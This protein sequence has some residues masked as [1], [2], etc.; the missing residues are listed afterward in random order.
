MSV[1][2]DYSFHH[3]R[4]IEA[5]ELPEG[6]FHIIPSRVSSSP[7]DSGVIDRIKDDWSRALG[8]ESTVPILD[9]KTLSSFLHVYPECA[10][11]E[12]G[13]LFEFATIAALWNSKHTSRG[14]HQKIVHLAH[15]ILTRSYGGTPSGIGNGSGYEINDLYYDALTGILSQRGRLEHE[16]RDFLKELSAMLETPMKPSLDRMSFDAYKEQRSQNSAGKFASLVIPI[17]HRLH[18]SE[19]EQASVAS[20][21]KLGSLI[22]GLASDY[23]S[24]HV[25]FDKH[26]TSD[27]L[28]VISN[29]MA[30]LM[31]NYGYTEE[32]AS[33]ILKS[34]ILFLERQFLIDYDDWKASPG[35]KATDLRAYMALWVTSVGGACY[36]QAISPRYHGLKLKTTAEDRAQLTGRN[37]IHYKLHG[38][39]PPASSQKSSDTP[40]KNVTILLA[41]DQRDILA[42]FKKAPAEQLCMAPYEYTR[43]TPGKKMMSKF[44]ECLRTW[45]E[46]PDTSATIIEHVTD[47]IFQSTLMIDDIED[48]SMLRRGKPAAHLV[49]GKSQTINSATYLYA[50][51]SRDL[52]QLQQDACKTA[53]LDELETLALGQALD[54]HWKFQKKCPTTSHY[55][56]MV[57]NKTGGLFRMALR[58]MEIE[59]KTEPCPDLMHLITLMGRYYQIRDDYMNLTSDEYTETKGYCEDLSEGKLS[60]PLIHALQNSSVADMIRGLLFHRENGKELSSEM[61]SYIV[62]EMRKAGSLAYARDSAMQLFDAMMETL[63]RV[64]AN[65]GPNEKLKALLR[66]LKL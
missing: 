47:M 43:A 56:N 28:E 7:V 29:A 31:A 10:P 39:P 24:F 37:K 22:T 59:S 48:D 6:Y 13:P 1:F 30:V 11:I 61:K 63:E 15:Q 25:D 44:I 8:K 21:I 58:V 41:G 62:A 38:Y 49:F 51:A 20:L 45:F 12:R 4:P 50:R 26:A 65:L 46:L 57:D 35:S 23:E 66:L 9:N 17:F 52:D 33:D 60:F 3:S 36:A 14:L 16:Q 54:L 64:E 42:P 32:E 34:V 55:L 19:D 27:S 5:S 2:N 18:I 53:F 40:R